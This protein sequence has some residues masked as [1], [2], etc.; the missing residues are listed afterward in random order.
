MMTM[1]DVTTT[2]GKLEKPLRVLH[3]EDVPQDAELVQAALESDGLHCDITWAKTRKEFEN[4]LGTDRYDFILSDYRLPDYDGITALRYVREHNPDM[5]FVFISGTVGEDAA[6]QSLTEGGTDYVQKQDLARLAPA[7]KRELIHAEAHRERRQAQA[8]LRESETRLSAIFKNIPTGIFIVHEKTRIIY[9]VNDFAL[10]TIGLPREDVVGKICH[11]FLCPAEMGSCPICDLGQVIDRAERV[12][13]KPDGT[14]VPILKTVVPITIKGDNYLLESFIDITER[15]QAEE[16]ISSYVTRLGLSMKA[17]NM[18]WWEMDI[19]TGRVIFDERKTD[20]LGCSSEKFQHYQDFMALVHPDDHDKAMNAMKAHLA[21]TVGKYEVEYRI[22]T[23]SGEYKWFYDIGSIEKR[24][25]QGAPLTAAGIVIDI[26]E[27]KQAEDELQTASE[28]LV[29]ATRAAS[30]GIWDWNVVKDE[31]VWDDAMYDLYG[32][33]CGEFGGAYDA[34]SHTIHPDDKARAEAAIQEALRGEREYEIEFRVIWP[35]G[36]VHHI[37]AA[38]MTFRYPDGKPRRMLGVN[39]D[40]TERKQA[41]E[42]LQ[43]Q[44]N[45][46]QRWHD[47]TAGREDR[48]LELKKEVNDLLE[49][50]GRPRKYGVI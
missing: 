41:E 30:I 12:L 45:E 47:V 34:W 9:E 4:A 40:I 3:L 17:A 21:G 23:K 39:Y 25:S 6:I 7:I 44:L 18:A 16:V 27:R 38:S 48:L 36:S 43:S 28:R 19:N 20:M 33:H 14:S 11:K 1:S 46:L 35:D 22:L 37:K 26:T 50:A 42:E 31:L 13:L 29:L 2:A 32:I 15:K 8:A 49:E 5:P 10:E 24:D